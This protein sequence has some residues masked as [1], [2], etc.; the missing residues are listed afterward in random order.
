MCTNCQTSPTRFYK[1]PSLLCV[2]C[3]GQVWI[4]LPALVALP[5]VLVLVWFLRAPYESILGHLNDVVIDHPWSFAILGQLLTRLSL[6]N[7]LSLVPFP[8]PLRWLFG[9]VGLVTGINTTSMG[10][11][12]VV[13]WQF[14]QKY[15]LIVGCSGGVIALLFFSVDMREMRRLEVPLRQWII[16]DAVALF[17]PQVLQTSWE[18]LTYKLIKGKPFLLSDPATAFQGPSHLPAYSTSVF[19][20]TILF[21]FGLMRYCLFCACC[22]NARWG[23]HF[24]REVKSNPHHLYPQQ[25]QQQQQAAGHH[26]TTLGVPPPPPEVVEVERDVFNDPEDQ[27][28]VLIELRRESFTTWFSMLSA[29]SVILQMQGPTAP[30][31]F[32]AILWVG[33]TLYI[34]SVW[35][36]LQESFSLAPT[37]LISLTLAITY[38]YGMACA[39]G[40]GEGTPCPPSVQDGVG[41]TLLV[42]YLGVIAILLWRPCKAA[43]PILAMF[44]AVHHPQHGAQRTVSTSQ[45]VLGQPGSRIAVVCFK[46]VKGGRPANPL[47]KGASSRHLPLPPAPFVVVAAA[48]AAGTADPDAPAAL[49]VG[50]DSGKQSHPPPPGSSGAAGGAAD[51]SA[52]PTSDTVAT[53]HLDRQPTDT[54]TETWDVDSDG[55]KSSKEDEEGGGAQKGEDNEPKEFTTSLSS[56]SSQGTPTPSRPLSPG[57]LKLSIVLPEQGVLGLR[58]A[59]QGVFTYIS[60]LSPGGQGEAHG[61]RVGDKILSINGTPVKGWE[62]LETTAL[63]LRDAAR[64]VRLFVERGDASDGWT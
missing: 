5:L 22:L 7:R 58:P 20:I 53:L 29:A 63:R 33:E 4:L 37:I 12:C 44:N 6:L 57:V 56:Q 27:K 16:W 14:E 45:R 47:P 39:H 30:L 59:Q 34:R 38:G 2:P 55:E 8:A 23:L 10:V 41:Y 9:V 48:A 31:I 42:S 13:P 49:T 52:C 21:V 62:S 26:L 1:S 51:A 24:K 32:L 36:P 15:W 40:Q 64:P 18:A 25:Q 19:L 46:R 61:L 3:T 11:D 50:G 35:K 17:L 54:Y 28:E 60:D 43:R